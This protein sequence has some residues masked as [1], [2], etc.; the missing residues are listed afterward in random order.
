MRELSS[1]AYEGFLEPWWLRSP[2]NGDYMV[3]YVDGDGTVYKEGQQTNSGW[4]AVRPAF[5]LDLGSV[6]LTSAGIGG[7]IS[8]DEG[9]DALQAQGGIANDRN[10][11]K[12]T[13]KDT[14]HASFTIDSDN[15][16][17][18]E[19][20]SS[21]TVPYSGAAV[22][23]DEYISAV[24]TDRPVTEK[25]AKIEYYGRII[26]ASSDED[27]S[28]TI[29]LAGKMGE[30]DKLYVFNEQING[31]KETDYASAFN[32][33]AKKGTAQDL[34]L[35]AKTCDLSKGPVNIANYPGIPMTL[36]A[37]SKFGYI[38]GSG[39]TSDSEGFIHMPADLDK[40]GNADIEVIVKNK[41]TNG[42]IAA[43][44]DVSGKAP[45]TFKFTAKELAELSQDSE[46]EPY[47]SSITFIFSAS[48]T[49]ISKATIKG[50]TAKT[51]TGKAL[52]PAPKVVLKGKTLKAGKDYTVSYKKN[53][54]V[55][56]A[57]VVIKGKGSYTGTKTKTFKINPKGT[58]L[59]S[60]AKA[61]K[62]VKIKWTKQSAKMKTT[63]ISGYQIIL[64][65][66]GNF[67]KGKKTVN[68]AGYSKI[69]KKVTGLKG[70][71]RYYVKLR[72]YKKIGNTKYYSKWSGIKSVKTAK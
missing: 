25:D 36:E 71:K 10:E 49:P 52:K 67:T 50:I 51:Y 22:G 43:Y 70:G 9:P 14:A 44:G 54:N 66:N 17:F 15:V 29:N 40:D 4:T 55:G 11:W 19:D 12:V 7:K 3:A 34:N 60:V 72:T 27:A 48:T 30:N 37:L 45:I 62:A 13:V 1:V 47:Y 16:V 69:S 2:G 35:G 56:T 63:R 32:E 61:S 33:V 38:Q 28:V 42:V 18:A 20:G 46:G 39:A 31:D 5:F 57:T 6:L 24:I 41:I 53:V 59:K 65:T 58:T 8:G 26:K 21:V 23:D 64:A 68:V